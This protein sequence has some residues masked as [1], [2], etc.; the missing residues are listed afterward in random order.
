MGM[1]NDD[2]FFQLNQDDNKPDDSSAQ[3]D[4]KAG[5]TSNQNASS[6]FGAQDESSQTAGSQE[7]NQN[8]V[9]NN[10]KKVLNKFECSTNIIEIAFCLFESCQKNASCLGFLQKILFLILLY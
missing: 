3:N 6:P 4:A 8:P 9:Q 5:N 2:P 7:S 1:E 10:S